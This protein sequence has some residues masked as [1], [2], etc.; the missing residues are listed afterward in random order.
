MTNKFT[1]ILITMLLL[2]SMNKIIQNLKV[3][4][5]YNLKQ[6]LVTYFTFRCFSL[7]FLITPFLTCADFFIFC[8]SLSLFPNPSA[9][10]GRT[11]TFCT[12]LSQMKRINDVGTVDIFNFV[13]S[14]RYRRCFM[15]QTEVSGFKCWAL[16]C[17]LLMVF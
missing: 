16:V 15:V 10:V 3:L 7:F 17:L 11:G 12:I 8:R 6:V 5:L 1:D 4:S 9:G 13:Q 14:M 2:Q